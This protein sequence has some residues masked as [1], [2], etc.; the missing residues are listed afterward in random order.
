MCY[1]LEQNFFFQSRTDFIQLMINANR[2]GA[3]PDDDEE[4]N[5]KTSEKSSHI[6]KEIHSEKETSGSIYKCQAAAGN[7][8]YSLLDLVES[9]M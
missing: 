2:G 5:S 7:S 9:G 3:T 6:G 8:P 1:K 4:H